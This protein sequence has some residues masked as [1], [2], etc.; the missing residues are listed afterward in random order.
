MN[1][2]YENFFLGRSL[3]DPGKGSRGSLRYP[4]VPPTLRGDTGGLP[5]LTRDIYSLLLLGEDSS[6]DCLSASASSWRAL[7]SWKEA[8]S[9]SSF[10][11]TSPRSFSSTPSSSSCLFTTEVTFSRREVI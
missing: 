7:S 1:N 11:V 3:G 8:K 5:I 9:W 6:R 2:F 10:E 4:P